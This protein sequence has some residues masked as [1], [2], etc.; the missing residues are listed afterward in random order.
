ME[1]VSTSETSV[2]TR[3]QRNIFMCRDAS[4]ANER[5]QKTEFLRR[6]GWCGLGVGNVFVC[7]VL[8]FHDSNRIRSKPAPPP[9][10][11]ARRRPVVAASVNVFK[12]HGPQGGRALLIAVTLVICLLW[13]GLQF[14]T[15]VAEGPTH[16]A[17]YTCLFSCFM[18]YIHSF[19]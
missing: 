6:I 5:V 1:V 17:Q 13:K 10:P 15:I 2:S 3:R 4:F 7:R 12:P 18:Q 9:P 14:L 8:P 19:S 11:P 16:F